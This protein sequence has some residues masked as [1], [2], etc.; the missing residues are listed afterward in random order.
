MQCPKE[1]TKSEE[2]NH[3]LSELLN[4]CNILEPTPAFF[5]TL[6]C[7]KRIYFN[8]DDIFVEPTTPIG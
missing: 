7:G 5:R 6:G 2:K 4:T 8:I 3:P 1:Q